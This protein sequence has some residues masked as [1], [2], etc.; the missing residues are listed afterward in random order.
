M[1]QLTIETFKHIVIDFS[2]MTIIEE[3]LYGPPT[4]RDTVM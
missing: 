2:I 3:D 4:K 1:T